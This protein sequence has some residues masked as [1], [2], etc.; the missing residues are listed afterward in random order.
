MSQGDW[1]VI[2]IAVVLYPFGVGAMAINVFFA[3][4]LGSWIGLSVLSAIWSILIGAL[5]A[6][7]ATWFFARHIRSLMDVA[8]A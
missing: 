4:L 2:R 3:S 1:S 7:P 8:S 5:I 6:V